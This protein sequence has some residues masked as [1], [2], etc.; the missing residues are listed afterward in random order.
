MESDGND[1]QPFMEKRFR[2]EYQSDLDHIETND[3]GYTPKPWRRLTLLIVALGTLLVL[4]SYTFVTLLSES[5]SE[6]VLDVP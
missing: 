1:R 5:R 6:K 2:D 4:A 3:L